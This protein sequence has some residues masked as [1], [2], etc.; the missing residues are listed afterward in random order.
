MIN[1]QLQS[2][3]DLHS[4]WRW[5]RHDNDQVSVEHADTPRSRWWLPDVGCWD[6]FCRYSW[7]MHRL[8]A[9]IPLPR[10][11]R[12]LQPDGEASD[13][14]TQHT[15]NLHIFLHR[16]QR[17]PFI[18]FAMSRTWKTAEVASTEIIRNNEVCSSVR[19][20]QLIVRPGAGLLCW[21]LSAGC[22]FRTESRASQSDASAMCHVRTLT[23]GDQSFAAA[24]THTWNELPFSLSDTGLSPTTFNE[25]V[26]TYLFSVA[27]WDHGAFVTFM[28]YLRC[29]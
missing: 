21:R 26:I 23:F 4:S 2:K 5:G 7:V 13:N 18:A 29:L 9:D 3:A 22:C 8:P 6:P 12:W 19:F 27:F 20:Y 1:K 15:K 28:I 24:G 16:S 11:D 25:H 17:R 14:S 10:S